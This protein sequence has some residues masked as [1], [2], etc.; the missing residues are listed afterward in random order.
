MSAH[1]ETL[2]TK[3]FLMSVKYRSPRG[4]QSNQSTKYTAVQLLDIY[5]NHI[6][7]SYFLSTFLL[8]LNKST[9][10]I[11]MLNIHISFCA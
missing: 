6:I 1:K 9:L 2:I 7:L 3:N 5:S 11:S 8:C 4:L 10:V